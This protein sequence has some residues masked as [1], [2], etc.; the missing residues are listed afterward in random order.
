MKRISYMKR[1]TQ[2]F[3]EGTKFRSPVDAVEA[4]IRTMG[5]W[6]DILAEERELESQTHRERDTRRERVSHRADATI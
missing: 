4:G 2:R 1:A 6:A 3:L 5:E